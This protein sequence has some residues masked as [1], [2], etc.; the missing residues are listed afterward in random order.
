VEKEKGKK[1]MKKGVKNFQVT[2]KVGNELNQGV[3]RE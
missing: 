2:T 3:R 1:E